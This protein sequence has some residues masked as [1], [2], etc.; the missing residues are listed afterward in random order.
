M[1]NYLL[2]E[3]RRGG[4][5]ASV[6]F[7]A[8][9]KRQLALPRQ[10][11]DLPLGAGGAG[12]VWILAAAQQLY[13]RIGTG[14]TRATSLRMCLVARLQIVGDASVVASVATK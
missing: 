3:L 9:Q 6:K 10:L 4:R 1:L 14:K 11:F 5:G 2:G 13:W 8:Q 7:P 12:T